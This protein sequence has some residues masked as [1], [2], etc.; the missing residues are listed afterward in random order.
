MPLIRVTN[1]S[2]STPTPNQLGIGD[3]AIN[4]YDGRAYLKKQVGTTQTV[5]EIGSGI[6]PVSASYAL[7]ASYL[8]GSIASA[9]YA[10]SSSYADSSSRAVSSSFTLTASYWSGS[11]LNATSASFASTA[12]SV[13][14]LSQSVLISGS[15][16]ALTVEPTN[17]TANYFP[18]KSGTFLTSSVLNSSNDTDLNW[19]PTSITPSTPNSRDIS[20]WGLNYASITLR[21][22]G[23][24]GN[25]GYTMQARPGGGFA[26]SNIANNTQIF[27]LASDVAVTALTAIGSSG[28]IA[29]GQSGG[30][31]GIN[32]PN[33]YTIPAKFYV[34]G[35]SRF[36]GNVSINGASTNSLT[37]KGSGTTSAT[38]ALLV[39]NANT[40][41][42]LVVRDDRQTRITSEGAAL[43]V[44]GAGVTPFSQNIAEF[45]YAGNSNSLIISQ[46]NGIA[47]L[48][49]S[50][51]AN[52]N[53]NPNGIGVSVFLTGKQVRFNN[54]ANNGTLALQ[55]NGA[56]GESRLDFITGSTTIISISGSGNVGIGTT[57]PQNRLHV[58]GGITGSSTLGIQGATTLWGGIVLYGGNNN[59]SFAL[60]FFYTGSLLGKSNVLHFRQGGSTPGA[61]MFTY[62]GLNSMLTLVPNDFNNAK[63]GI[64]TPNPLATLHVSGSSGSILFEVDSNSQQNILYVSGSGNVG[65]GTSNPSFKLDVS[66]SGRFTNNLTVTGSATN[67]LLVK[68]SGTTSATTAFRV[69]NAN[70]TASLT[71]TDSGR[72]S[73]NDTGFGTVGQKLEILS[74]IAGPIAGFGARSTSAPM[75]YTIS[76]DNNWNIIGSNMYFSASAYYHVFTDRYGVFH[77]YSPSGG[78]TSAAYSIELI[79]TTS[80]VGPVASSVAFQVLNN[81][82]IGIGTT[83]PAYRLDVSGSGNFINNL[84]VTGS[85]VAASFTGS[86]LGTASFALSSSFAISSS[87]AIS[88]S[89]ATT[90]SYWSGSILNATSASYALTASYWS[91]SITN[92]LSASYSLTASFASTSSFPWFPT[93]S[94]IAYVGGNVGVGTA[95]P[96]DKFTVN[97]IVSAYYDSFETKKG[98]IIGNGGNPSFVQILSRAAGGYAYALFNGFAANTVTG[99]SSSILDYGV[100]GDMQS[101]TTAPTVTYSYFCVGTASAYN[102]THLRIYNNANKLITVDGNLNVGSTSNSGYRLYVVGSGTTSATTALRIENSSNTPSL[103]VLDNGFVGIRRSNPTVALDVSGSAIISGSVTVWNTSGIT[104]F[105]SSGNGG[106]RIY[107]SYN[108]ANGEIYIRPTGAISDNFVFSPNNGMSIGGFTIGG[109]AGSPPAYGLAVSGSVG[110]GTRVPITQLDVSGSGR[111]TSN[112]TI[113]GS[114]VTTTGFTGSLLG[115]ASYALYAVGAGAANSATSASYALSSSYS[116]SSSYALSSSFA[117]SSSYSIS[118]SYALSSSFAV[119]SSRA[120]SS[121]FATTASYW[122]GSILNATSASFASTA[123]SVNPL[124]QNVTVTG[125]VTATGNIEAQINLKSMNQSGDEGGEIFLNAPATNTTIPGGVTIDVYQNR[126]RIFEQ[127]G[128]ANGYYLDMPSGGPGVSTDLKPAGY[129]GIVNI[130]GNPPGQQFLNFT[131]GILISVT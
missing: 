26:F 57:T 119:S 91:G 72:V 55:N 13:N 27:T 25:D 33:G 105:D 87:R 90:A 35:S 59:T 37:V 18:K 85:V 8:Q 40:S 12:S 16:T 51:D 77:K 20:I 71:I 99:L 30:N 94:N 76:G 79:P 50:T 120:I 54:A 102:N 36:D 42:S 48:T 78:T 101:G 58:V 53:F 123:S 32:W 47:G 118:S 62:Y 6:T 49:T 21:V 60:D 121:S 43:Y 82:N 67:S 45:R 114:V 17:I 113:T 66:G 131:D 109:T 64:N 125:S 38:N 2:G 129:T 10:L 56:T 89:F 100:F 74:N 107:G 98:A 111:F 41:A 128:A 92:A 126:L 7:T 95:T 86:L 73:I 1:I 88:S 52:L 63:V 68:G 130:L 28:N 124:N 61:I 122:S 24:T 106:G 108:Y 65:I 112:L 9:S 22:S 116:V 93:G 127:G 44:E 15:L 14:P 70:L 5:I 83:T 80:S 19:G 46:Q 117:V 69:E 97:G 29:M 23:S 31:V 39:Q 75:S 34:S 104:L 110:I 103:T 11:I 96:S 81:G 115:T 4:T 84:T 3:I